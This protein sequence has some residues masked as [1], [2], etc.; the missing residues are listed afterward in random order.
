M[1]EATALP[2]P[3]QVRFRVGQ[4]AGLAGTVKH[5]AGGS[6]GLRPHELLEAALATCMTITARMALA[7][8][9]L[10]KTQDMS[11][12][13]KSVLSAMYA[14]LDGK[15]AEAATRGVV[16]TDVWDYIKLAFARL[17]ALSNPSR[18]PSP[19]RESTGAGTMRS[20]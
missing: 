9:G 4:N 3:Y 12:G 5:G 13:D 18:Q 11:G 6:A 10:T 16:S 20:S 8:L 1:A 14:K 17:P 19:D 7:E 2:A 15:G